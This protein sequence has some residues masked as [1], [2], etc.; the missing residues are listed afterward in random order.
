[1]ADPVGLGGGMPGGTGIRDG[2]R[3]IGSCPTDLDLGRVPSE[4]KSL[5]AT[6]FSAQL[7]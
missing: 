5:T 3:S 4:L 7:I 1:M 2:G 6:S